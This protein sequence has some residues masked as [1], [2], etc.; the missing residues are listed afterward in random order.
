MKLSLEME[1]LVGNIFVFSLHLDS[2][3]RC[4][5]ALHAPMALLKMADVSLSH[6]PVT[7][8]SHAPALCTPT[9][10]L[11]QQVHGVHIRDAS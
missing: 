3:N 7:A 2:A 11:K 10:S 9:I 8:N 1:V 5:P 4:T 6:G